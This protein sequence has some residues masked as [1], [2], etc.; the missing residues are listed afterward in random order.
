MPLSIFPDEP[1]AAEEIGWTF[2]AIKPNG[3]ATEVHPIVGG[4]LSYDDS[5]DVRCTL[6]GLAWTPDEA[7]KFDPVRDFLI[8][9]LSLDGVTYTMGHF[10]ATSSSRQKDVFLTEEETVEDI[11]HIDF[12]DAFVKL[13]QSDERARAALTGADP[14]V[15]IRELAED[16]GFDTS[17]ANT[18]ALL[19]NDVVWAPFT[20][21]IEIINAL[22]PVAGF[23]APWSDHDGLFRAVSAQ[24][25]ETEIIPLDD[26]T[27]V[28]NSVVVSETYLSAPNR[29]VVWDDSALYP[30]VGRWEAPASAPHS[31][32]N[33]GYWVTESSQQ[34]GLQDIEAADQAA[35]AIG[36]RLTAR[37]LNV[38]IFPTHRID[39]PTV[40]SYD[41]ALWLIRRW[42][43]STTPGAVMSIEASELIL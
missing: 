29:V 19:G 39:G 14:A 1:E 18:I 17:I 35:A 10:Y 41:D 42:D 20:S 23:R 16:A 32:A 12:G 36:E 11:L 15:I 33:R 3:K 34:Q 2:S 24:V 9:Y 8:V 13:Q 6:T 21:F 31:F 43:L 25:I 27:P 5:S 37:T 26:L 40:I 7:E 4:S 30:L 22:Y 38:Q 28:A